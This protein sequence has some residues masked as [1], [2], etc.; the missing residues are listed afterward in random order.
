MYPYSSVF[1]LLWFRL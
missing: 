1:L